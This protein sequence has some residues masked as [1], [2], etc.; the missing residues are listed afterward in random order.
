M[1]TV[2]ETI[3]ELYHEEITQDNESDD[4]GL[5]W[6]DV[7]DLMNVFSQE[8][9]KELLDEVENLK[10]QVAG[11]TEFDGDIIKRLESKIEELEKENGV[12]ANNEKYYRERCDAQHLEHLNT[13]KE[14]RDRAIRAEQ[15]NERLLLYKGVCEEIYRQ[16][17]KNPA[18]TNG[19][20]MVGIKESEIN[21]LGDLLQ[22]TKRE[23]GGENEWISVRKRLP[24]QSGWYDIKMENGYFHE[25]QYDAKYKD[26]YYKGVTHWRPQTK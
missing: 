19:Y 4:C 8:S 18:I 14:S 20:Y 3:K 11:L 21:K 9:N 26:W 5:S 6:T 10:K 16:L 7:T 25:C 23:K 17:I 12:L 2:E 15:M 22:S 24:E 1:K 13:Q